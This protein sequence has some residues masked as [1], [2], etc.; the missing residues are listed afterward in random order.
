M[1]HLPGARS[2]DGPAPPPDVPPWPG[3]RQRPHAADARMIG[4][5]GRIGKGGRDEKLPDR[6]VGPAARG[7]GLSGPCPQGPEVLVR[8]TACGVC[9]SDL[10]IWQGFFDL[11]GGERI[12]IADRGVELPFTMGH[13]VVG[14]VLSVGPEAKDVAVGD[15]RIV[16]PLIGCGKCPE[17][18]RGDEL[19]C[20]QPRIVGTWR[21][22]GYSDRVMCPMPATSSLSTACRRSSRPPTPARASRPTAPSGRPASRD[23]TRASS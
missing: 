22:G 23:R 5:A 17:C 19:M 2:G 4:V 21:P 6:R 8:V 7:A 13:E 14:E 9:H 3:A 11:G 15:R 1:A 18:L 10:H 16:Y 12:N 20:L